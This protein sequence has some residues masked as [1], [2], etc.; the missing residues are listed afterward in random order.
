M[1]SL[2][3]TSENLEELAFSQAYLAAVYNVLQSIA[4]IMADNAA[5]LS[6]D[7]VKRWLATDNDKHGADRAQPDNRSLAVD[8]SSEVGIS[9]LLYRSCLRQL[10]SLRDAVRSVLWCSK[11][12]LNRMRELRI[13]LRVF[14]D[15][16]DHGKLESCLGDEELQGKIMQLLFAV[17]TALSR[18]TSDWLKLACTDAGGRDIT[19]T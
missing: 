14:G 4:P 10:S 18:G 16:F 15:C 19:I 5:A 1:R 17:G 12:I 8:L 3:A 7:L 2:I 9:T 13:K 11:S 6:G